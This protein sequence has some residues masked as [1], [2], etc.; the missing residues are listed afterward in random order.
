[1]ALVAV[2][3]AED[4]RHTNKQHGAGIAPAPYNRHEV[5]DPAADREVC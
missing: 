5:F 1:M 3:F 4:A 2:Q